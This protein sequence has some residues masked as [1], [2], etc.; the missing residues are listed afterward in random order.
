MNKLGPQGR[1]IILASQDGNNV[2]SSDARYQLPTELDYL[3]YDIS[4]CPATTKSDKITSYLAYYYPKLKNKHNIELLTSHFLRCPV[5]FSSFDSLSSEKCCKIIECFQYLMVEKYKVTSPTVGF[6]DF[7]SSIYNAISECLQKDPNAYWKVVP[8]LAGCI[9]A[10]SPMHSYNPHPEYSNVIS[11][12]NKLCI[13]LYSNMLLHITEMNVNPELKKPFL[14]SLL[15]IQEHLPNHFYQQLSIDNP[16]IL[17]ELL[18]ILFFSKDGLD[19]GSLLFSNASV[20]DI[21]KSKPVLKHLNKWVFVYGKITSHLRPSHESI[22]QVSASLDYVVSFC[23]NISNSQLEMLRMKSDKWDLVKY[24]FFTIIMIFEHASTVIVSGKFSINETS[25][26]ISNQILRSLFYLSFILDQIGT[27]GFDAYN[28]VFDSTTSLLNEKNAEMAE[29]LEYSLLNEIPESKSTF[30]SIETSKL[31]YFLRV[32]EAVLPSLKNSFKIATLFPLI[33]KILS[34]GMYDS[35]TVE[36]AHSIMIKHLNTICIQEA[37][38]ASTQE[39]RLH[40]QDVIF[41][42]FDR[43]LT[44]FP[45]DLSLAQ[46]S[47]IVQTCGRVS[48]KVNNDFIQ[49]LVDLV[50]FQFSMASYTLLPARTSFSNGNEVTVPEKL[51]SRR[52]G[53]LSLLIDLIQFVHID[54]FVHTLNEIKCH[55]DGLIG[56]RDIYTLYDSLWDQLLVVNKF[57]CQKGQL[58]MDWWFDSVNNGQVPKL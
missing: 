5:F 53:L 6:Q 7:Y 20:K 12:L 40:I 37:N 55:I 17:P 32:T 27:G 34:T 58:G 36:F 47:L 42:Y 14:T 33:N 35:S 50:L 41:P 57:D 25:F 9:A 1:Q 52:A 8:V 54:S 31:N 15:Y 30:L 16:N 19:K 11:K 18:S 46:A 24:I 51:S 21:M 43:V 39:Y 56:A 49:T 45:K 13:S 4:T 26:I 48:L 22:H 29:I 2:S 3:L 44:Q 23:T 28:F 38:F 10:I